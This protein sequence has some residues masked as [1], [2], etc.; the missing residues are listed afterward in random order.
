MC[1]HIAERDALGTEGQETGARDLIH[2]D[3]SDVGSWVGA[4]FSGPVP[5]LLSP[6]HYASP[7]KFY[8]DWAC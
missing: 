4:A 6:G 8:P 1:V 7:V 2:L 5:H 3:W